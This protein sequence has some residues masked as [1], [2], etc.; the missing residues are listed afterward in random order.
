MN[1]NWVKGVGS[2]KA[3]QLLGLIF[4]S[5]LLCVPLFSQATSGRI[6][7]T[8]TDQSGGAMA[9]ANVTITDVD[10]NV[11]RTLNT[12]ASGAYN[13][14]S[15]LPGTYKV[16]AEAKGFKATERQNIIVEVGGELRIDLSMQPGEVT[17]TI[18]VTEALP[19]VET[20]NAELGGTLQSQ[21]IANLP[22]NG[23]NFQ[24]ML[25]SEEH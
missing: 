7:G 23:R 11:S 4:A 9:G 16:R 19:M 10:R 8:G 18:T 12:D 14:P 15:L 21:V 3:G 24:N 5:L 13:A 2:R 25:R 20:T 6:Q 1:I 17:Q 22:L